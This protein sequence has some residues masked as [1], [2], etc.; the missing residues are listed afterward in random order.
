MNDSQK[1]E[2]VETIFDD[3]ARNNEEFEHHIRKFYKFFLGVHA[4]MNHGYLKHAD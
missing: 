1:L 4:V 2:I 3:L